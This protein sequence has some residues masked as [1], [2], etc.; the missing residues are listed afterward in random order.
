MRPGLRESVM[1][2]LLGLQLLLSSVLS[3]EIPSLMEAYENQNVGKM[4]AFLSVDFQSVF[5]RACHECDYPIIKLFLDSDKITSKMIELGIQTALNVDD[6]NVLMMLVKDSR[7]GDDL[8]KSSFVTACNL[9]SVHCINSLIQDSR[10]KSGVD[11]EIT[12]RIIRLAVKSGSADTVKKILDSRILSRKAKSLGLGLAVRDG[13]VAMVKLF[14][15]NYLKSRDIVQALKRLFLVDNYEKI[16][17]RILNILLND[18]RLDM[19]FETFY[20]IVMASSNNAFIST[21]MIAAPAEKFEL[22]RRIHVIESKWIN[23]GPKRC[24]IDVTINL[25]RESGGQQIFEKSEIR[26]LREL[27]LLHKASSAISQLDFPDDIKNHIR[28]LAFISITKS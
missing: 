16:H 1:H 18:P 7:M 2:F 19:D 10:I 27:A 6:G 11:S 26:E 24:L 17:Q 5:K 9:G 12:C 22:S 14:L 13:D 20:N 21:L 28:V 25:L 23:G 15:G 8:V 4:K 3:M